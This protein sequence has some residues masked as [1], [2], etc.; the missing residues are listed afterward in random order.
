MV[1]SVRGQSSGAICFA[2]NKFY[3]AVSSVELTI[4]YLDS[5]LDYL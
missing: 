2:V 3:K 1:L 4:N 5:T